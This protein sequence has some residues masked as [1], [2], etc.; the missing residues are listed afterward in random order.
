[1]A[2]HLLG[3]IIE[4]NVINILAII[5]SQFFRYLFPYLPNPTLS[6]A[7]A[8]RSCRHLLS[9]SRITG[10]GHQPLQDRDLKPVGDDDRP[11]VRKCTVSIRQYINLASTARPFIFC[12]SSFVSG[13][14]EYMLL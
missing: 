5:F 1:M 12:A 6:E 8:A 3:I 14:T 11:S 7:F 9:T 2:L 4:N 13:F 10:P